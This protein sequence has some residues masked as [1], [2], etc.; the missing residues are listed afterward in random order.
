MTYEEIYVSI[1]RE[2]YKSNKANLLSCQACL[3]RSLRNLNNIKIIAN[4][5]DDLRKKIFSLA[6]F[7]SSESK[8]LDEKFAKIELPK[9]FK[10]K[11]KK[12][13]SPKKTSL[14]QDSIDDELQ[15]IQQKLLIL[16]RR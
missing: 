6:S 15:L 4:L 5:K 8:S 10:Q 13:V 7:I 1:K 2:K 16:N 12:E 14:K 11:N 9:E 3:L